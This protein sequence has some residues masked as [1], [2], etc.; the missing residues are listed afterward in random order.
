[1][2]N[3]NPPLVGDEGAAA[4]AGAAAADGPPAA[5]ARR[6]LV[7][8]RDTVRGP[9][10]TRDLLEFYYSNNIMHKT[11][12][13]QFKSVNDWWQWFIDMLAATA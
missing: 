4:G 8:W 10:L 7:P 6:E 2:Q 12:P 1:M 11:K 5:V 13:D 3:P 9:E